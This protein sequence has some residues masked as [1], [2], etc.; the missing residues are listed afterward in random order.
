MMYLFILVNSDHKA[1]LSLCLTDRFEIVNQTNFNCY[2]SLA[3][4]LL[5]QV[6]DFLAK[7]NLKPSDLKGIG[8]F[9]G[10]AGFTDLRVTHTIAN[11]LAYGLKIPVVNDKAN[12]WQR[13]C[14]NRL[15]QG[16]NMKIIKPHYGQPAKITKPKK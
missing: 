4:Q 13:V 1:E 16:V 5:K 6:V 3:E 11:S 12:N 8:N 7:N 2:K 9:A 14:F 15:N 10:P